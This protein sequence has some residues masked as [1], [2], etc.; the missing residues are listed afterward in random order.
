[1][2]TQKIESILSLPND[3]RRRTSDPG[4]KILTQLPE[5]KLQGRS[6]KTDASN[7]PITE[8]ENQIESS[9]S[10]RLLIQTT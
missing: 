1:M 9:I 6:K 2:I 5:H 10:N 8:K 3:K 4:T 7:P